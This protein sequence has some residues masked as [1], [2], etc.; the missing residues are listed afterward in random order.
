MRK[1]RDPT[2]TRNYTNI[3]LG[4]N[5]S[6]KDFLRDKRVPPST[7]FRRSKELNHPPASP[8]KANDI[9]DRTLDRTVDVDEPDDPEEN[10]NDNNDNE[11]TDKSSVI[12]GSDNEGDKAVAVVRQTK[13]PMGAQK[14]SVQSK[15]KTHPF[16]ISFSD[17]GDGE[18]DV[19]SSIGSISVHSS[20]HFI[21]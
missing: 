2:L 8:D 7:R 20:K 1:T 18:E 6:L 10:G 14:K 13:K 16:D 3:L 9:V 19:D 4:I 11:E 5:K 21:D 15:K 17:D 12:L